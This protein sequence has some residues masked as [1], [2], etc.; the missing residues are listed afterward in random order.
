MKEPKSSLRAR[1]SKYLRNQYPFWVSGAELEDL[2]R[3]H[4]TYKPSNTS[5]R[6][7]EMQS[8][9]LSNGKTCPIVAENKYNEKGQVLYRSLPPKQTIEYKVEDK[10]IVEHIWQ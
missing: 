1:L 10:V 5:R 4:T 6:L 8:G 7:R 9:Q 3:T 2:V